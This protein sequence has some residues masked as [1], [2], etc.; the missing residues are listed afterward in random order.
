MAT[1]FVEGLGNIEIQGDKPNAEEKAAIE[2]ALGLS[3]TDTLITE[4]TDAP[5]VDTADVELNQA[6]DTIIPEMIDPNLAELNKPEGLEVIGG[7]PTFEAV[8][9]IG[10]SIVGGA[11]LNPATIVAGGT[12]GAMGTGQLYDVLQSAITGDTTDFKTQIGQAKKDFQRE[13]V[14]QSFFTK[15][16]G[17]LSK[18]KGLIF[19]KADKK[20]YDS[21]QKIGFPLSLSDSGNMIAKGYGTVVGN[22]PYIGTP[23]KVGASK[24][25][26]FLN[27]AAD[28][29]L[30]TF[31]PNVTLTKLGIDMSKASQKTY[32]DFRRVSSFFYDDFY[33]S[34]DKIGSVPIVS[35]KNFK[36]SLQSFTKLIDDGQLTLKTGKKLKDPRKD[37]IYKYAKN[38]KNFPNHVSATQYKA[39]MDSVKY[40]MKLSKKEPFDLKVLTG[41]KSAL[42]T[43]LRLLTKKSYRDDLLTNV[44]PLSSSKKNFVDPKL[45][46][47]IAVK[48][49]FADKVYAEG[50]EN[51][52]IRSLKETGA[53]EKGANI[54]AIPGK[55][56]FDSS[57]SKVF[58]RT[59]K[60]IFGTGFEVPGSINVDELGQAL[61]NRNASPQL[62]KDLSTLVGPKQFRTFVRSKLQKGFDDSL[63]KSGGKSKQGLTFDPY[64]FEKNLGLNTESGREILDIM[65]KNSKNFDK[66]GN[67]LPSVTLQQLDDFFAIAKN[68]AGLKIPNVSDFIARRA[69]L[70]GTS[71]VIGSGLF[72]AGASTSPLAGAALVFIARKTSRS[73]SSV[74]GLRDVMKVLDIT[75]PAGVRK[76]TTL[77]LIDA[78]ISDSQTKEEEN[79]FKLMRENIELTT[80]DQIKK[81]VEDTLNSSQ[82]FLNM[83]KDNA[84]E[85][86][87][88]N[89]DDMTSIKDNT[90]QLPPPPPLDTVGVNPASFDNKIMAQDAN[91]L[92]QSEQAFLDDEE[93]AMRLRSR[94]ITA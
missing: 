72:L 12:L 34:M 90:S 69:V 70:G 59:D 74:G 61:L 40:Y 14:L 30:N 85:P 84:E 44:Y 92:T 75:S 5:F 29:T 87:P 9:A 47:D 82:Q 83:N 48:L 25:A 8:G 60:N 91:G 23:L 15:I 24:K 19:G 64:T 20:L 79:N 4:T 80:L 18:T 50:L 54:V 7:R 2:N 27:K 32:G 6:T 26:I 88:S 71:A 73:L 43:D 56:I 76:T 51:S 81:G 67:A 3:S 11:G 65:L 28:D 66:A 33:S 17:L 38:G 21:A 58:K 37:L 89:A 53:I 35:T 77:K 36:N 94:G 52:L 42:E 86:A 55:K 78:M 13:A 68:H 39:L 31:G 41:I 49:K 45:L 10:G 46:E 57:T 62:L 22:F 16:P 93:K 63:I 1:I